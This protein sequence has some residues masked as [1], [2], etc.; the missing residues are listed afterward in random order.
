MKKTLCFLLAA[1]FLLLC[2]CGGAE[3]KT[4]YDREKQIARNSDYG[5]GEKPKVASDGEWLYYYDSSSGNI[6]KIK[7]TD[8][9]EKQVITYIG[10]EEILT[11]YLGDDADIYNVDKEGLV[12]GN[13][14]HFDGYLY[15]ELVI[16]IHKNDS[17]SVN[18]VFYRI[19]DGT[20]YIEK[21]NDLSLYCKFEGGNSPSNSIVG[22]LNVIYTYDETHTFYKY[23]EQKDSKPIQELFELQEGGTYYFKG[24][25]TPEIFT[26]MCEIEEAKNFQKVRSFAGNIYVMGNNQQGKLAVWLIS[27]DENSVK[28]IDC[29]T[30]VASWSESMSR[31]SWQY[32]D[33]Y[34]VFL[35]EVD[36][37]LGQI[38]VSSYDLSEQ[39]A[40]DSCL[41]MVDNALT[42]TDEFAITN[43]HIFFIN[44]NNNLCR[45][46]FDG[47]EKVILSLM[48]VD[49]LN[50]QYDWLYFK[51]LDGECYRTS[52]DGKTVD[53]VDLT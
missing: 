26:K 10:K 48:E 2:G 29:E 14:Y 21:C 23:E 47:S 27:D 16:P 4:T 19:K 28:S 31:Y 36:N 46:N 11:I 3:T 6:M 51:T 30:F 1:M 8:F 12:V 33:D 53:L 39:T 5:Y 43:D 24:Y 52:F 42:P 13:F 25:E 18:T 41:V 35:R 37:D 50:A 17:I 49:T 44:E 34:I 40:L 22:D 38:W 9:S 7:E 15:F 32:N 20:N 45:V